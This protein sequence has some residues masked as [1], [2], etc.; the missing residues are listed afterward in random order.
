MIC[1]EPVMPPEFIFPVEDWRVVEREFAPAFLALTETLFS[2]S[3]GYLGMRGGFEEGTPAYEPGTFI[4]GFHET[5]PP[6]RFLSSFSQ[7]TD[8]A[9]ARRL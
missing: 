5:W 6:A 8:R 2:V 7:F 9:M 4:N 1:H 3:N